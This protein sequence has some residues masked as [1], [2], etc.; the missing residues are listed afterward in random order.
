[1]THCT[2]KAL[3]PHTSKLVGALCWTIYVIKTL[4]V[5]QTFLYLSLVL[6]AFVCVCVWHK[7]AV[8]FC[9]WIGY[10]T[11]YSP[12]FFSKPSEDIEVSIMKLDDPV[13]FF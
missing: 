1:M 6:F 9:V 8:R 10:I 5:S 13:A 3:G 7:V 2:F 4:F 11:T 12:V